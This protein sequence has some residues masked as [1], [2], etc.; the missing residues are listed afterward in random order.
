[1]TTEIL[2]RKRTVKYERDFLGQLLIDLRGLRGFITVLNELI[3]NAEDAAATDFHADICDDALWI[4]NNSIFE[5]E[6]LKAIMK[7]GSGSKRNDAEKIG[8]FGLGFVSVYQYADTAILICRNEMHVFSP[9]EQQVT[10]ESAPTEL[11]RWQ[12]TFKLPWAF[13]NSELREKLDIDP[14][15]PEQLQGFLEEA[16]ETLEETVLFLEKLENINL[17]RNG[18]PF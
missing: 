17:Y 18:D 16:Q 7:I 13:E 10:V 12:T 15:R 5:D 2:V 9:L 4:G 8:T 14:V 11:E 6:H 1:M 3:Q